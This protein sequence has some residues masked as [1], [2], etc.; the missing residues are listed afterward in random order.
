MTMVGYFNN[1]YLGEIY[2]RIDWSLFF[3]T[4]SKDE[5]IST[6]AVQFCD[7]T[8]IK[9]DHKEAK[10]WIRKNKSKCTIKEKIDNGKID[11]GLALGFRLVKIIQHYYMIVSDC[12]AWRV[13]G[14]IL[15]HTYQISKWVYNF[16]PYLSDTKTKRKIGLHGWHINFTNSTGMIQMVLNM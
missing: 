3:I 8:N 10:W 7:T 11:N 14:C 12:G 5:V 2:F 16:S 13:V 1:W 9:C 4:Q 6:V 15:F